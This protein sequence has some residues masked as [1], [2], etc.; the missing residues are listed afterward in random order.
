MFDT[1]GLHPANIIIGEWYFIFLL[2]WIYFYNYQKSKSELA[3]DCG[4]TT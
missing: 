4:E 3:E 1:G 2:D